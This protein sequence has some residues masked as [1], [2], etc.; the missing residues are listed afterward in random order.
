MMTMS[1]INEDLFLSLQNYQFSGTIDEFNF[2]WHIR[3]ECAKYF[4]ADESISAWRPRR[5][6][7]PNISVV[8]Q[9]PEPLGKMKLLLKQS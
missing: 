6:G 4:C 9:K 5:S 8:V 7:L 3:V 1:T 2:N